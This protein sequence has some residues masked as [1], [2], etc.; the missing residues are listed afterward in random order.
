MKSH[1]LHLD[2]M[3]T[4]R[5]N[6]PQ[7]LYFVGRPAVEGPKSRMKPDLPATNDY[8]PTLSTRRGLQL[9]LNIDTGR[10][11]ELHQCIDRLLTRVEHV[12]QTLVST[13][14]EL[15]LRILVDEG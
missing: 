9:D 10:K 1:I 3:R 11:I 15:L 14:L 7:R 12:D 8:F 4:Y 2:S 6:L 5:F 13:D